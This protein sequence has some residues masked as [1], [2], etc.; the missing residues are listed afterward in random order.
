MGVCA[1]SGAWARRGDEFSLDINGLLN[2]QAIAEVRIVRYLRGQAR[3]VHE[4]SAA[5]H[6]AANIAG[7]C[8]L[9]A[10]QAMGM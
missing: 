4:S 2:G 1:A 5:G 9:P 10:R 7:K 3:V 6:F 8:R